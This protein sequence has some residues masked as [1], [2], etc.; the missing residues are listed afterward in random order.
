[1]SSFFFSWGHFLHPQSNP[2]SVQINLNPLSLTN[3]SNN[4]RHA[5]MHAWGRDGFFSLAISPTVGNLMLWVVRNVIIKKFNYL[6]SSKELEPKSIILRFLYK[7]CF[8]NC[9]KRKHLQ[10]I[11][12]FILQTCIWCQV[13]SGLETETCSY[14]TKGQ[15]GM[16]K[17]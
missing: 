7:E 17:K 9:V 1:M 6:I 11:P 4:F 13:H 3:S 5:W 10:K 12:S 15:M 16:I 14:T 8:G 2:S